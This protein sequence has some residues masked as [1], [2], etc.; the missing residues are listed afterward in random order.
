MLKFHDDDY[1]NLLRKRYLPK[2][3]LPQW[4]VPYSDEGFAIWM[5]RLKLTPLRFKD[6]MGCTAQEFDVLNH[7]PLRAMVGLMLEYK[8]ECDPTNGT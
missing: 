6:L 5:R 8:A 2:Y 7:W 4:R 3:R 1:W